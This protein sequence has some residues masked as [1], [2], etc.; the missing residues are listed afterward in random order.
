[1]PPRL[2]QPLQLGNG[3]AHPAQLQVGDKPTDSRD[4]QEAGR[5]AER[6]DVSRDLL[7]LLRHG[8]D[9]LDLVIDHLDV[10]REI[11][12]LIDRV[13]CDGGDIFDDELR[14]RAGA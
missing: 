4:L 5:I 2:C 12:H 7:K 8:V 1:M 9:L 3:L 10:F 13:L 11:Q 6:F 14:G